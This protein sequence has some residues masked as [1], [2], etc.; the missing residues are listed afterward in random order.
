MINITLSNIYI[1]NIPLYNEYKKGGNTMIKQRYEY[2]EQ[3]KQLLQ[4]KYTNV[5][6][7]MIIIGVIT[8]LFSAGNYSTDFQNISFFSRILS[9]VSFALAAGF[10]FGNIKM[11]IGV[12]KDEN[13]DIQDILLVGFKTNY[14]RN[15]VTSLLQSIYTFL[16]ALLLII[17][18]IIKAYA[19]SMAF[20]LLYKEP[21]LQAADAITKSK[22]YTKGYKMDL[23]LLHL[24]YI[25]WYI[26]SIFT[27]GILLFWV[28]P[29]VMTAQTL[30]F[31]EIYAK[32]NPVV[33]VKEAE[34]VE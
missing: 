17:P 20:Y 24:S 9:L 7:I 31:D 32:Y 23:F 30:I 4:G 28:V 1:M 33:E 21:E 14:V 27:L 3:A 19:Y 5:I 6:V 16:W 26:L 13:P 12:I 34:I 10:A 11:Y 15:L 22:E 29:K 18:G 8:S 2:K 25:G